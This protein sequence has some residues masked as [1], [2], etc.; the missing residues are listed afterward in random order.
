[1][2]VHIEEYLESNFMSLIHASLNVQDEKLKHK[3]KLWEMSMIRNAC[4]GY[5]II[6]KV[7]CSIS[8]SH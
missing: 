1:M 7:N 2:L 4:K 3:V 5:S 6:L 8:Y